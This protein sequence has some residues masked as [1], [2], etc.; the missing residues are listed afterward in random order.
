M[1]KVLVT[2]G[3][4]FI[5]SAVVRHLLADGYEVRVLAHQ[6][7]NRFLIDHLNIEMVEGDVTQA[8]TV[9]KAVEGCSIVFDLASLYT[10]YPFWKKAPRAIYQI[11][12]QGTVNLLEASLRHGVKKFIHTGTIASIGKMPDGTPS[13]EDTPFLME[14]ASHY[15]RSKYL[16][17]QE[18]L[19][20]CRKGL[21]AVILSP[22]IVVGERDYKPTP[23]GDVIVKFLNRSL[24]CYFDTLWAI[25][26]VDDVAKAHLSAIKQGRSGERYILCNQQHYTLKEIFNILSK[27]SGVKAPWLKVPYPILFFILYL[28]EAISHFV[29]RKKPLL[30][31]EGVKFCK[32]SIRFDNS[33]AVRELNYTSTPIEET[34]SKAVEWY[35]KNAYVEAKGYF[36]LKPGG[37]RLVRGLMVRLGLAGYTDKFN[38]QTFVFFYVVQFMHLLRRLGVRSKKNGWRIVTQSYLRTEHSKFA[39]AVFGLDFWSDVALGSRTPEAAQQHLLRRLQKFLHDRPQMLHQI[40]WQ[41][42]CAVSEQAQVADMVWAEFSDKGSLESLRLYLDPES[43]GFELI[44]QGLPDAWKEILIKTVIEKYN[45]TRRMKDWKRCLVLKER[46]DEWIRYTDVPVDHAVVELFI[47]RLLSATFISFE[48]RPSESHRFEVPSFST[49]K[50]AGFGALNICCRMSQDLT[51]ADLWIQ[52]SHIPVDGVPSQEVLNELKRLWGQAAV[53][54]PGAD[55]K[56]GMR[57]VLVSSSGGSRGTYHVYKFVNFQPFLRWRRDLNKRFSKDGK[58]SITSA[59]LFLWRLVGYDEFKD[60]KFAVPVD[61]AATPSMDR[62]LG[63]VF[64][65]P[66]AYF[67]KSKPDRGFFKFQEDFNRQLVATR[68]HQGEGYELLQSYALFTPVLFSV[69]LKV[70]RPALQDFVGTIGLTIIKKADFFIAPSGDVHTDGF[71]ALSNFSLRCEGGGRVSVVSIKGPKE[72]ITRYIQII[73]EILHQSI[74]RDELYF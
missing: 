12:V 2:G 29:L 56:D 32:M 33:K 16:A 28:D 37:S 31:S 51:G 6:K 58:Q 50:H 59:A 54:F 70:F 61:L 40:R 13:N 3:T 39:L 20:Y 65:R 26:D 22:A 60:I 62:T 27:V 23:S 49:R 15:A 48:K 72:K 18:V 10:F 44:Q 68:K 34:L 24:P 36:R 55:Y 25:A 57:P 73:D 5:G 45:Q 53:N 64:I 7:N 8:H 63:L 67:D 4:G 19:K 74:E 11:N 14:G 38:I 21:D 30:P 1:A 71:I 69:G 42:F 47:H 35:R 52:F 66:G 46:L 43:D 9:D 41:S 17:E